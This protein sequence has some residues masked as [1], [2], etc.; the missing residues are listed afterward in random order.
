MQVLPG[1]GRR[2]A[3]LVSRVAHIAGYKLF[4]FTRAS[5]VVKCQ[6]ALTCFFVRLSSQAA[7][8]DQDQL[9]GDTPIEPLTRQYAPFGFNHVQPTAV[10]WGVVPLELFDV[11]TCFGDGKSFAGEAGLSVLRLSCTGTIFFAFGKCVSDNP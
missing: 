6:S 5:A 10:F 3:S 9:V 11:P 4:S 8:L 2:L 1:P 7:T